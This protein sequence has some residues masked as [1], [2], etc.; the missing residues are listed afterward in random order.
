MS[1]KNLTLGGIAVFVS[2][3]VATAVL[4]TSYSALQSLQAINPVAALTAI[5]AAI[6]GLVWF[7]K[8]CR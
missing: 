7:K 4:A 3:I 8:T 5:T 6:I 1:H 2:V